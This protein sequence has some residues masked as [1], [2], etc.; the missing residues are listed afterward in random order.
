MTALLDQ[1]ICHTILLCLPQKTRLRALRIICETDNP[2]VTEPLAVPV[3]YEEPEEQQQ[4][5][6][7]AKTLQTAKYVS[8]R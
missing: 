3:Y 2:D 4:S 7:S 8:L 5:S 6:A 1:L